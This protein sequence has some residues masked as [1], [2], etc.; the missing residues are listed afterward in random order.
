M[1]KVKKLLFWY[2]EH[3]T[4]ITKISFICLDYQKNIKSK[5]GEFRILILVST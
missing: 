5:F 1:H 3:T 2:Y 4:F